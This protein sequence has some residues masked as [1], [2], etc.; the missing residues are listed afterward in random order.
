[1]AAKSGKKAARSLHRKR[2]MIANA[3]LMLRK[4]ERYLPMIVR[5]ILG[6]VLVAFG[7]LGFLPI[8]GFWMIPLGLAL[9]ALD[10]P[11]LKH[12]MIRRLQSWRCKLQGPDQEEVSD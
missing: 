9:V 6:L 3:Y 5:S 8:L 4:G 10:I 12:W 11:P 2:W 1:M 7:L